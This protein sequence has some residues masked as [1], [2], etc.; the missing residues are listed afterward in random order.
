MYAQYPCT[1][2]QDIKST[3]KFN[4]AKDTREFPHTHYRSFRFLFI[5]CRHDLDCLANIVV[6]TDL[7]SNMKKYL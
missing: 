3:S 5:K 2:K 1:S 6:D 7:P 4:G